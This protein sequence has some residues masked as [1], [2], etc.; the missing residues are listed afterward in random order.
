MDISK[1]SN[2]FDD[3]IMGVHSMRE[4]IVNPNREKIKIIVLFLAEVFI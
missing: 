1:L 2:D 3:L 4:A